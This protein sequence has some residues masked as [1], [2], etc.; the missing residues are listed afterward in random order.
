MADVINLADVRAKRAARRVSSPTAR[1]APRA[2]TSLLAGYLG[3]DQ[4]QQLRDRAAELTANLNM[5]H[6]A[7]GPASRPWHR[8]ESA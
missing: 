6:A 2:R 7:L 1:L 5:I 4:P 3:A 8:P